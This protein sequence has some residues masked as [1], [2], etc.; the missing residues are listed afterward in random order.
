MISAPF[1][2]LCSHRVHAAQRQVASR[3]R[4]D[5]P[6][7]HRARSRMALAAAGVYG[8]SRSRRS[9][10]PSRARVGRRCSSRRSGR[11]PAA[12][13]RPLGSADAAAAR[14][15]SR[16]R[17]GQPRPRP[18][19]VSDTS[20][21]VPTS[22][23]SSCASLSWRPSSNRLIRWP[24]LFPTCVAAI[25]GQRAAGSSRVKPT[26]VGDAERPDRRVLLAGMIDRRGQRRW[27]S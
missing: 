27:L 16:G 11:C 24:H 26:T 19:P 9:P 8:A 15:P 12:R 4:S 22:S 25:G 1:K 21:P 7:R 5:H 17:R 20:G 13:Q 10:R 14:C 3:V 6:S 23:M 2:R 18:K